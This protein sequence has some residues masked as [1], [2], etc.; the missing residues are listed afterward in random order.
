MGYD[1]D[2]SL[3]EKSLAAFTFPMLSVS[4]ATAPASFISHHLQ[5][6][7]NHKSHIGFCGVVVETE[8]SGVYL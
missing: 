7:C 6:A 1:L 2:V 3:M 4:I 8:K 5:S